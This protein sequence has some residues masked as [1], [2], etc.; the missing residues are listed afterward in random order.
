MLTR[1]LNQQLTRVGPSTPCGDLLRRYWWPVAVAAQLDEEPVL[2]VRLLG[3]SLALYR[4]PAGALGLVAQR[5]PHRGASLAYG[6]PEDTGLRCPYHGWIFDSTGACLD[7]PAEP[8]GS[9]FKHRVRIPAYPVRDLGGLIFA[10]LGPE[11][12]PLLPRWDLLVRDDLT[13]EVGVCHLPVNWLQAVENAMDPAHLEVLHTRYM[14][15]VMRRRGREPVAAERHHL[16][17]E[18]DV[19]EFGISKRR[20]LEGDPED[21]DEWRIGHPVIFPSLL[22]LGGEPRPRLGFRVPV[23]D[24]HTV[25]YQYFTTTR[26]PG[27]P[28]QES[29]PFYDIPIAHD[30][31]SLIVDTVIGQD[32]MA[33]ITQ[34]AIT[35]RT[36][37]RLG[38]TDK[39]IVLYRQILLEQI[40]KAQRGEDPMGVIRDPARNEPMISVPRE[41]SAFFTPTGGMIVG[42]PPGSREDPLA[43]I[44]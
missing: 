39:G 23:D 3:E 4:S 8:P 13:R 34:G 40:E 11:P 44:R 41:G 6:I 26:Q 17:M 29:M 1:E 12:V 24:D 16:K 14:N 30:D 7:M 28:A 27:E 20:L 15:Y 22:S 18:F 38:T 10:Y 19:W 31:G 5:C 36:T 2:P 25:V 33:I 37:E 32:N 43:F 42:R 21:S 35:D 9:T